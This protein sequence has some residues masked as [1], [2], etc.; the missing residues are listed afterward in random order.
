M[1]QNIPQN[2]S[3]C[4]AVGGGEA[5]W[6]GGG[7]ATVAGGQYN[8]AAGAGATVSGGAQNRKDDCHFLECLW[9]F[10]R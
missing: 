7:A 8:A 6:A 5:N 4:L 9:D 1:S 2:I 3:K 10:S